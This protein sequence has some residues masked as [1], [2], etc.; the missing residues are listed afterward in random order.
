MLI[1]AYHNGYNEKVLDI[2]LSKLDISFSA[3]DEPWDGPS[4]KILIRIGDKVFVR[5][6]VSWHV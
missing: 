1:K 6:E 5:W 4:I 2:K 3:I